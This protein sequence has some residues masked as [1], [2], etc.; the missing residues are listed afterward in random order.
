MDITRYAKFEVS[1]A[2]ID[3]NPEDVIKIF[4]DVL[5]VRAEAMYHKKTIEYIG[6]SKH[7]RELEKGEVTPT[8]MAECTRSEDGELTVK[9]VEL[10]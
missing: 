4:A 7:F 6:W 2:L 1:M 10:S 8:Y 9:W 3:N 5:V